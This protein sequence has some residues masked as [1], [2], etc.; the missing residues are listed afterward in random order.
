VRTIHIT[1]V[2]CEVNSAIDCSTFFGSYENKK[3]MKKILCW[4][5]AI[6]GIVYSAC[7]DD[8][9]NS[10]VI[11]QTDRDFVMNVSEGNLAEIELGELAA[12]KS[13][14]EAVRAFGEMMATEHQ[15]AMDEL[16]SIA[17]RNDI[18]MSTSLN[19][20]HQALKEQLSTL[21]GYS[22]DTTY[23]KSQVKDH[24]K[25]EALFQTE[26]SNGSHQGIRNY[27]NKYLPHIQ[28]HLHHADSINNAL[29]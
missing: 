6:S 2:K 25:T 13:T 15:M 12:M 8:D 11:N 26:I 29:Q 19:A 10:N 7:D 27:A 16:D 28:M 20:E 14:T 3:S 17:E 23:M 9:D 18:Q 21:V 1:S 22:F 5:L 24:E 4:A